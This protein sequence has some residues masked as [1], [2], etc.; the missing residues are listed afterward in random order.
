VNAIDD[1]VDNCVM[2][3]VRAPGSAED[4]K[5]KPLLKM[6]HRGVDLNIFQG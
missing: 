6:E 4:G 1:L 2:C 5:A 3:I